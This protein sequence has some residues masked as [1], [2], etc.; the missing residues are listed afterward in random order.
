MDT[1][2]GT[3]VV[4]IFVL[5]VDNFKFAYE[6]WMQIKNNIFDDPRD[7]ILKD[8]DGVDITNQPLSSSNSDI[9][10]VRKNTGVSSKPFP[11]GGLDTSKPVV[12]VVRRKG[13]AISD[14]DGILKFSLDYYLEYEH[15]RIVFKNAQEARD[16]IKND[17][18]IP[19]LIELQLRNADQ[20]KNRYGSLNGNN[21]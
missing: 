1:I 16:K 17:W 14:V 15:N 2:L 6:K 10:T 3:I 12:V 18:K 19:G 21:V 7:C 11:D 4:L 20:C 13:Y 9:F 5:V 8:S